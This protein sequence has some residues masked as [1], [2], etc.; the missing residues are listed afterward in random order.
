MK[1]F[2]SLTNVVFLQ[3]MHRNDDLMNSIHTT[4]SGGDALTKMVTALV[5]NPP[6][7]T[8]FSCNEENEGL[9]SLEGYGLYIS[10]GNADRIGNLKK[11][12]GTRLDSIPGEVI[13]KW[14]DLFSR[15]MC[16]VNFNGWR[17]MRLSEDGH[18]YNTINGWYAVMTD[19]GV[20]LIKESARGKGRT[21][22]ILIGPL[23]E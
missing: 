1:Q 22:E 9:I 6:I 19:E 12:T 13:D 23:G 8:V 21:I 10:L 18:T 11:E 3:R 15:T 5:I 14:P 17:A 2:S 16:A 4:M 7:S 20:L